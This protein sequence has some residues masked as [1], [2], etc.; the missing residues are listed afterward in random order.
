[1]PRVVGCGLHELV[2]Q[3]HA[4]DRDDAA[5]RSTRRATRSR[6]QNPPNNGTLT[7]PRDC[8]IDLQEQ[9][10]FDIAGTN[11]VGYIATSI[12]PRLGA[13]HGRPVTGRSR[14][15]GR[16]AGGERL[17]VTGLAAWQD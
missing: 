14:F 5:T 8:G 1:M 9:S 2:V 17:V 15:A 10:G 16:I 6:S 11:N 7:N 12:E 3:R 4:A 13:V